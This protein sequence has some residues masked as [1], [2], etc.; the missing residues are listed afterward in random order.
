M[1]VSGQIVFSEAWWVGT[2][3]DNPQELKLEFPKEF[4]NV[5]ALCN[6]IY[7]FGFLLSL[8]LSHASSF[9]TDRMVQHQIVISEVEQVL[10]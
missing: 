9:P 10:L 4:Q 8:C 7:L 3:Q 6:P 2:K 5:C 1:F